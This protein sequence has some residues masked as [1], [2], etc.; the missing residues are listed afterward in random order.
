MNTLRALPA[1]FWIK[2]TQIP[3]RHL[4]RFWRVERILCGVSELAHASSCC[5]WIDNR[6]VDLGGL[7]K[8]LCKELGKSL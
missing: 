3:L 7:L 8:F 4:F 5:T 6:D 2:T 1:K